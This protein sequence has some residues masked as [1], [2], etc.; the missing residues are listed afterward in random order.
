MATIRSTDRAVDATKRA[1]ESGS[2]SSST[3]QDDSEIQDSDAIYEKKDEESS[4]GLGRSNVRDSTSLRDGCGKE[5]G[6]DG[7]ILS[8][9]L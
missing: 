2:K 5:D 1:S 8:K 6:T 7:D 9:E 3:I 4:L